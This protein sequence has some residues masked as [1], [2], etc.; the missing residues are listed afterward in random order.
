MVFM[1]LS[2]L[3]L[4]LIGQSPLNSFGVAF[5]AHLDSTIGPRFIFVTISSR[6]DEVLERWRPVELP[7]LSLVALGMDNRVWVLVKVRFQR[8]TTR[9]IRPIALFRFLHRDHGGLTP[10]S[11]LGASSEVN[12]W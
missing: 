2:Y 7:T 8:T 3:G 5:A 12:C 4:F 11:G 1:V 6:R 9:T 10:W